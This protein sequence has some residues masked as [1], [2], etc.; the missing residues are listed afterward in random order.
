MRASCHQPPVAKTSWVWKRPIVG[1]FQTL[2]F[3]RGELKTVN[4]GCQYVQT[5][6]GAS[7]GGLTGIVKVVDVDCLDLVDGCGL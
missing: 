3:G 5:R 1:P 2:G 7:A 6:W 4:V